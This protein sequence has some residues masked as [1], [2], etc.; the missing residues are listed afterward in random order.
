MEKTRW[1]DRVRNERVLQRVKVERNIIRTIQIRM[2]NRIGH[3]WRRNCLMKH[4][5]EGELETQK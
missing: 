4:V 2:A 5:I 3:I 1:T